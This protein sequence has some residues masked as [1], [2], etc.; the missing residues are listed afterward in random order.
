[1]Q[2][3]VNSLLPIMEG[4]MATFTRFPH[5]GETIV[6]KLTLVKIAKCREIGQIWM[7]FIDSQPF[8][9]AHIQQVINNKALKFYMDNGIS[10]QEEKTPIHAAAIAGHTQTFERLW[11]D[12]IRIQNE[13]FPFLP[14]KLGSPNFQGIQRQINSPLHFA[15]SQGHWRI[16]SYIIASV[17]NLMSIF[18]CNED[19]E[20]QVFSDLINLIPRN[21]SGDTPLHTAARNKDAKKIFELILPRL[22]FDKNPKNFSGDTPLHFAAKH[23]HLDICEYIIDLITPQEVAA[24]SR[25]DSWT[26]LHHAAQK[27]HTQ[28]CQLII[29]KVQDIHPR[30]P[31]LTVNGVLIYGSQTPRDLARVN[32]HNETAALFN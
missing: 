15:A 19:G 28:I 2:V 7:D 32:G 23:G 10:N 30:L 24:E 6:R 16:C 22:R 29:E 3:Q 4:I 26:P 9:Q 13:S 1:M 21:G 14:P 17:Q 12:E 8:F 31:G 5:L 27:G 25:N 11:D 18:V 20:I